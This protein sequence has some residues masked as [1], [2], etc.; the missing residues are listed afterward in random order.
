VL[1]WWS[2]ISLT[3][4]RATAA[5]AAALRAFPSGGTRS[6]VYGSLIASGDRAQRRFYQWTANT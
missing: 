1:E 3:L 4:I 2:R 6:V 5:A